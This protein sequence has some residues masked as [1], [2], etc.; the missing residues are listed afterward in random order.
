MWLCLCALIVGWGVLGYRIGGGTGGA[1]VEIGH[2]GPKN[3][4]RRERIRNPLAAGVQPDPAKSPSFSS[5]GGTLPATIA[6]QIRRSAPPQAELLCIDTNTISC[7]LPLDSSAR[8]EVA[9]AGG[10]GIALRTP[11]RRRRMMQRGRPPGTAIANDGGGGT[12]FFFFGGAGQ[13]KQPA[14]AF[15]S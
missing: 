9:G 13:S 6:P 11:L 8:W 5:R 3:S 7:W 1:G 15:A 14:C 4:R 10:N 2:G 12:C